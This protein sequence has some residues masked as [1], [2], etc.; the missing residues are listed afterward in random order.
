MGLG[1]Y[2]VIGGSGFRVQG[3]GCRVWGLGFRGRMH[4][5]LGSIYMSYCLNIGDCIG[6]YYSRA[7]LTKLDT[8][9]LE[10]SSYSIIGS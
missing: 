6:E 3:V 5:G 9:S 2:T 7:Y 4:G 10:S 8:R 1:F